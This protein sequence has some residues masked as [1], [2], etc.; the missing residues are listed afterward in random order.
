[1]KEKYKKIQEEVLHQ[2]IKE[3]NKR[4]ALCSHLKVKINQIIFR[5]NR[6]NQFLIQEIQYRAKRKTY[7]MIA[8]QMIKMRIYKINNNKKEFFQ[9]KIRKMLINLKNNMI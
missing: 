7:S 4:K 5:I 8:V 3:L 1:M 6:N 2:K 9:R